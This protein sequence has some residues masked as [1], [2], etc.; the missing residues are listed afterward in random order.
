MSQAVKTFRR[1]AVMNDVVFNGALDLQLARAERR[2]EE[3]MNWAKLRKR[4][5]TSVRRQI[6]LARQAG[7]LEIR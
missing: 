2:M 4:L 5:A 7:I 6:K 1:K 3:L